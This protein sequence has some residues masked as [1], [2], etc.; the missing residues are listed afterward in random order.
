MTQPPITPE[1]ERD[2]AEITQIIQSARAKARKIATADPDLMAFL[3]SPIEDEEG[4]L[5]RQLLR[6]LKDFV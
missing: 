1:I 3:R 4:D 2:F 6:R 5:H